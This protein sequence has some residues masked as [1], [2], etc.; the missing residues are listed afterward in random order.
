MARIQWFDELTSTQDEA[1]AQIASGALGGQAVWIAARRQSAGRGRRGAAWTSPPGNLAATLAEPWRGADADA[2]LLSFFAVL[3]LAEAMESWIEPADIAL[4]WPNDLMLGGAKAAGILPERV[5]GPDGPWTAI[6]FGVNVRAAPD[7]P[8]RAT[9]AMADRLKPGAPALDAAALLDR[10]AESWSRWRG[11]IASA[12]L[13]GVFE[14]AARPAW[15]ARAFGLGETC[16]VEGGPGERIVGVFEDLGRDGAMLLR[17]LDGL[18]PVSAGEAVFGQARTRS[19]A[20]AGA[21]GS[22]QED[23]G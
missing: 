3:A 23:A 17:T 6:G 7:I 18:K 2:P 20:G 13:R 14:T 11:R 15:L 19:G 10:L 9:A 12:D 5:E 22:R 8:G 1:K 4:K 16:T 21:G